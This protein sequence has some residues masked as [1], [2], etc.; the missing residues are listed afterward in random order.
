FSA[1]LDGIEVRVFVEA[2]KVDDLA[3][4]QLA[5]DVAKKIEQELKYPG[6]IKVNI[7][8]ELRVTEYAR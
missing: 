6:E 4:H 2:E 7:I 1:C 5:R 3:A 8:R